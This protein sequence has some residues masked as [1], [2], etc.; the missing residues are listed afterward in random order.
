MDVF[1]RQRMKSR[2]FILHLPSKNIQ[3]YWKHGENPKCDVWSKPHQLA[4]LAT[5][6][7]LM[8]KWIS[9]LIMF[10]NLHTICNR[11]TFRFFGR[12]SHHCI[13]IW[14]GTN[15]QVILG[16]ESLRESAQATQP[17]NV[18][19]TGNRPG[20]GTYFGRFNLN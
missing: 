20:D 18:R 12:Y 14:R 17:I 2:S 16:E 8:F 4:F 15:W 13:R 6:L 7:S 19:Q 3:N 1:K 5:M 10:L 11:E 9:K